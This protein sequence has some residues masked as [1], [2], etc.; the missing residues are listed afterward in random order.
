MSSVACFDQQVRKTE[1]KTRS[2]GASDGSVTLVDGF[3]GV[4]LY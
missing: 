1:M 2:N 3:F 4:E